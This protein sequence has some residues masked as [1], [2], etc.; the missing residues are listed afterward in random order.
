M[1][2]VGEDLAAVLVNVGQLVKPRA[3]P[4]LAVRGPLLVGRRRQLG[5]KFRRVEREARERRRVCLQVS[6][7]AGRD[8][9]RRAG[10][11]RGQQREHLLED[12]DSV[13]QRARV[14]VLR[15]RR[16]LW[17][18]NI[19][20]GPMIEHHLTP[21]LPPIDPPLALEGRIERLRQPNMLPQGLLALCLGH[22]RVVD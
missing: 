14:V 5:H 20:C 15:L 10:R 7:S 19:R 2:G 22:R 18:R 17:R 8:L 9:E 16:L 11:V 13:A 3:Q 21:V 12:R 4:D 6:P 1:G